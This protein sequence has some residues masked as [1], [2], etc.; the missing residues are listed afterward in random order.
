MYPESVWLKAGSGDK[1]IPTN[2]GYGGADNQPSGLRE[3][4]RYKY[5]TPVLDAWWMLSPYCHSFNQSV[6]PSV[7]LFSSFPVRTME[8]PW[9]PCIP[10]IS[11]FYFSYSTSSASLLPRPMAQALTFCGINGGPSHI[12]PV[13]ATSMPREPSMYRATPSSRRRTWWHRP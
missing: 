9:R 13:R 2:R 5:R 12:G 3:Y 4:R 7:S 6:H 10:R 8:E 1:T 11:L